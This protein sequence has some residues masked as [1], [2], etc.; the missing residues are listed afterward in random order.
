MSIL[1]LGDLCGSAVRLEKE[2]DFVYNVR[3]I[4]YLSRTARGTEKDLAEARCR[5]RL[6]DDLELDEEAVDVVMNLRRQ[7][8]ALQGR[9]HELEAALEI[10]QA[11]SGTR[12]Q[13]YRQVT[14]ETVWEEVIDLRPGNEP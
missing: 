11:E 3:K 12:M 4:R 14:F 8:I 13:R 9:L 10:Y 5:R 2:T 6:L 1:H 7:V